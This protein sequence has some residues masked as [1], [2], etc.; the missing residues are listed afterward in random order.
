MLFAAGLVGVLMGIVYGLQPYGGHTMG[1]TKPFVL[2]CLLG[3]VAILVVFVVVEMRGGD[4]L[5]RLPLFR[6]RAFAMGNLASL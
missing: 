5:F 1:W 2:A 4:P 6:I 3:G